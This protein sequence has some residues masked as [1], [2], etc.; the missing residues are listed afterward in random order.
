MAVLTISG[1]AAWVGIRTAMSE[2]KNDYLKIA[3]WVG[4]VGAALIGILYLWGKS[5]VNQMVGLP[6]V[7]VS[8]S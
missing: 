4:G 7:R 2:K 6:A 8:P 1:A 3:G 5:G